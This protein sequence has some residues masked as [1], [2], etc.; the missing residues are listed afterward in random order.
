MSKI[1]VISMS[2]YGT[3]LKYSEG[4]KHNAKLAKEHFP[5]WEFRVYVDDTVNDE[6]IQS[7]IELNTNVI[8]VNMGCIGTFYRFLV[9]DDESVDRFIIRDVD[10]RLNNHD[11]LIVDEWVEHGQPFHVIRSNS[12]SHGT[13]ILAGLWG[14]VTNSIEGFSMTEEIQRYTNKHCRTCDQAFLTQILWPKIKNKT[15]T[16]GYKYGYE[17]HSHIP[18][19]VEYPIEVHVNNLRKNNIEV[20]SVPRNMLFYPVG[21]VYN[22]TVEKS[23][24]E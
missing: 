21:E 1:N 9:Y 18:F 22:N 14:G 23:F 24:Y 19:S 7:L 3:D 10:D 5:T 16:H 12:T 4:V 15:L 20:G 8:K 6:V 2:L 17:T 11:K 13:E